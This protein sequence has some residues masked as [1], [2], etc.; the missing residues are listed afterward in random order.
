M[1]FIK[2]LIASIVVLIVVL[3]I[4]YGIVIAIK[5]NMPNIQLHEWLIAIAICGGVGLFILLARWSFRRIV[6]KFVNW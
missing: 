1:K 6:D 3:G 5:D 4:L 2:D